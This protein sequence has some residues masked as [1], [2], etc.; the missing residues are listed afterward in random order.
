MDSPTTPFRHNLSIGKFCSLDHIVDPLLRKITPGLLKN[1]KQIEESIDI[2]RT[3]DLNAFTLRKNQ[4]ILN[5]SMS[6]NYASFN[7]S[8]AK[9]RNMNESIDY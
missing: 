1:L 6:L 4:D 8:A 5:R 3:E 2:S 9:R 7:N